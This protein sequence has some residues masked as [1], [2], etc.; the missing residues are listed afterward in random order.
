MVPFMVITDDREEPRRQSWRGLPARPTVD[1]TVPSA[2][3]PSPYVLIG[4]E[5]QICDTL[6]ERR[7]RWDMSYYVFNDDT[8]DTVAPIVARLSGT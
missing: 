2:S 7:E 6:V 4:T 8:I 1:L 5:D 3:S